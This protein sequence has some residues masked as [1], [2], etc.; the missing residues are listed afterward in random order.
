MN[1]KDLSNKID[2]LINKLKKDLLSVPYNSRGMWDR[3]K[4]WWQNITKT[5]D[6]PANPYYLT[7]KFG[8]LG[9]INPDQNPL[10]NGL[11]PKEEEKEEKEEIPSEEEFKLGTSKNENRISLQ[12]YSFLKESFYKL[13]SKISFAINENYSSDNLKNLEMFRIIDK[14]AI[15]F[16]R[17]IIQLLKGK[18]ETETD[19]SQPTDSSARAVTPSDRPKRTDEGKILFKNWI[20]NIDNVNFFIEIV[21]HVFSNPVRYRKPIISV[22][23]VLKNKNVM[24]PRKNEDKGT[25][26]VI[27]IRN[28]I[29]RM[30]KKEIDMN[31]KEEDSEFRTPVWTW[32]KS[33][34]VLDKKAKEGEE[35]E[36]QADEPVSNDF[37]ETPPEKTEDGGSFLDI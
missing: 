10:G 32:A 5:P 4:N 21:N 6:N 35:K 29:L 12:E 37:E 24:S 13:E 18:I 28:E 9:K 1:E 15:D 31:V 36:S 34:S 20:R 22:A 16:K 26:L 3:V 7:N 17:Q 8:S 19:E 14:W 23:E 33:L 25:P 27:S 2:E 30:M 11:A